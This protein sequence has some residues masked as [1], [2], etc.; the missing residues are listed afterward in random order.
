MCV[1]LL[2]LHVSLRTQLA[3]TLF[4]CPEIAACTCAGESHPGPARKDGSYVGRSAPEIDIFE[5]TVES[6]GG[7]V[8]TIHSV[9]FNSYV[10]FSLGFSI[11]LQR[12]TFLNSRCQAADKDGHVALKSI[13]VTNL[14]TY[15]CAAFALHVL[16]V[17]PSAILPRRQFVRLAIVQRALNF[18]VSLISATIF[19]RILPIWTSILITISFWT[20]RSLCRLNGRLITCVG[21][22]FMYSFRYA[23]GLC[24]V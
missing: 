6:D 5:A 4:F 21:F 10:P 17:C 20:S 16:S 22:A 9:L 24:G 8:C 2:S 7:K 3:K 23:V 18:A 11:R 15:T 1:A 12:P 13:C 19:S 14:F